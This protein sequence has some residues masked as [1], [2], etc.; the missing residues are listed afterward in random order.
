MKLPLLLPLLLGAV[1]ARHLGDNAPPLECLDTQADL[2]QNLDCS[3]EQKGELALHRE[4]IPSGEEEAKDSGCHE[5]L[6]DKDDL[7]SDPA[8][9]G[10][11]GCAK[12]EDTVQV[13]G[14]PRC[15]ISHYVV[16]KTPRAFLE[17]MRMCRMDYGGNLVSIHNINNN[18][19]IQ[20]LSPSSGFTW[21]DGSFWDFTN[22]A[23]GQP[24][25][26][27]GDCVTMLTQGPARI[28][29]PADG[30]EG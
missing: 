27:S 11:L 22:W 12:E 2:S 30:C 10:D 24:N 23:P 1:S 3:G 7:D 28:G 8:A 14:T 21:T 6:E 16:V 17:A 9:S 20:S 5:T 13:Q 18:N 4:G 15:K 19:E 26:G 29:D 25:G